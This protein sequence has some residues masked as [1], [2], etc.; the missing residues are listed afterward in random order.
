MFLNEDFIKIYEELSELNEAK[1]D[2]QRLIDFA[3]ED[4]ANRFLAI[5]NRLKAP[6]NDLYYW[7]KNTTPDEFE[8]YLTNV[9][10]TQSK[11]Q[12]KKV[13]DQGA[14]LVCSS[15]HWNVYHVTTFAAAQK[16]GRDSKWCITGIN[17]WGDKYWK[18]YTEAGMDFYFLITKGEYDPRGKDSKIA[19]AINKKQ[20]YCEVFNQQDTQIP[21]SKVPYIEEVSLP[22]MNLTDLFN[23]VL[24]FECGN[25]IEETDV[26]YGPHEECYCE[27]C[28]NENFYRCKTCDKIQYADICSFED[29]HNDK[30]CL[31]CSHE[32]QKAKVNQIVATADNLE[33]FLYEVSTKAPFRS[34]TG[35]TKSKHELYKRILTAIMNIPREGRATTQVEVLSSVTGEV[36]YDTVGVKS[37]SSSI[38]EEVWAA[39][40]E[41]LS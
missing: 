8:A 36:I 11:T 24:C 20:G 6:E 41:Y 9:E 37:G 32:Q 19:I 26:Y 29:E 15:E 7:I 4:L 40:E 34:F 25:I 10:Q 18:E 2:T 16:Y 17:N 23:K 33:N 13:A 39:V 12:I 28:F 14:E 35:I 21:L 3:G 22:T 30:F 1:A 31:D 38:T 5:K 27:N